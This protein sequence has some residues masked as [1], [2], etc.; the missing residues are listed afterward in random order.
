MP[1]PDKLNYRDMNL[2]DHFAARAMQ[3]MLG[4]D[5]TITFDYMTDQYI[6]RL[7]YLSFKIADDMVNRRGIATLQLG[8]Y[9]PEEQFQS[10][11]LALQLS[12]T[13]I[14]FVKN[15]NPRLHQE[16]NGTPAADIQIDIA[17]SII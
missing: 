12:N 3:G 17:E 6:K 2:R 14:Q 11:V 7:T 16:A 5:T 13:Y 15:C 9:I 1:D 8:R 4:G 10:I